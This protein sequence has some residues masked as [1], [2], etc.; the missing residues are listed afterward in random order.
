[1]AP[2]PLEAD[3]LPVSP[4]SAVKKVLAGKIETCALIYLCVCEC[5]C[6]SVCV[7][8][9]TVCRASAPGLCPCSLLILAANAG[10]LPGGLALPRAPGWRGSVFGKMQTLW[11]AGG[12]VG[13][14]Q[15][16]SS[17]PRQEED[18]HGPPE[19][20]VGLAGGSTSGH[21]HHCDGRDRGDRPGVRSAGR[22]REWQAVGRLRWARYPGPLSGGLKALPSTHTAH[23]AQM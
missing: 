23:S 5:G 14:T 6:V 13:A 20:R 2:R 12:G 10:P 15:L 9:T 19:L 17:L 18:G 4:V 3:I 8:G 7:C 22:A 21:H 1:M 11:C 16:S